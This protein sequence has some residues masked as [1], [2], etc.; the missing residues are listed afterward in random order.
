MTKRELIDQIITMNPSARPEFLAHFTERDL[1]AYLENL[2][3]IRQPRPCADERCEPGWSEPAGEAA[4]PMVSV[5]EAEWGDDWLDGDVEEAE[6]LS[7]KWSASQGDPRIAQPVIIEQL[8][9][10]DA[11]NALEPDESELTDTDLALEE[12][13]IPAARGSQPPL[14]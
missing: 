6:T 3:R 8:I 14:L 10:P 5:V 11:L 2:Q 7:G 9:D 4:T 12:A 1:D 13:M